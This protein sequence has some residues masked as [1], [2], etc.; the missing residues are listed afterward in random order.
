MTM[1]SKTAVPQAGATTTHNGFSLISNEKLLELYSTM[2]KCRMLQTHI[3]TMGNANGWMGQESA[4][5]GEACIAG[6]CVDLLAGDTLAPGPGGFGASFVKGLPVDKIFSIASRAGNRPRFRYAT[7]GL[8]P[9]MLRLDAQLKR[10]LIAAQANKASRNKNL[11]VAF[12][13]EAKAAPEFL[14]EVMRQAGKRKLPMLLVCNS[15]TDSEDMCLKARECGFPGMTVDGAD[16]VAVYRVTTEAVTHAR[17]G[18][19]P[20]LVD[21][22]LWVHSGQKAI[23]RKRAADSILRME[24][25]LVRKGLFDKKFKASV[26]SQFRREIDAGMQ[27]S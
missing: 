27:C 26:R 20:T 19:G 2:L 7:R 4:E 5:G 16:A 15:G 25:Y 8:I 1:A 13:G 3:R 10:A 24:E 21:C 11:V 22:K 17:R 6:L 18:N 14:Y 9:P 23:D 12:C